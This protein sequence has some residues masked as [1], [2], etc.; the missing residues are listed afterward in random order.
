MYG[1]EMG[2][3]IDMYRFNLYILESAGEQAYKMLLSNLFLQYAL[4]V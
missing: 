1:T 2:Y 4:I 3:N